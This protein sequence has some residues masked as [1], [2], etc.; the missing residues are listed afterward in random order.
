MCSLLKRI[1]MVTLLQV[2]SDCPTRER[3]G[4]T[5]DAQAT[6]ETAFRTLDVAS[7]YTKWLQD[8]Q[9][10]QHAN[11]ALSSTIPFAKHVPPVDPSWPTFYAQ[12]LRLMYR[13]AG[14]LRIVERHYS[15]LK[16]S[17]RVPT[18]RRS[19]RGKAAVFLACVLLLRSIL[20]SHQHTCT[21]QTTAR[22]SLD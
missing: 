10:A 3:V 2:E 21:Y 15:N 11:G 19:Q 22:G 7:F 17:V 14:D 9:D 12:C 18:P 5:G 6:A 16:R 4:W 1:V 20:T 13:Y 8:L